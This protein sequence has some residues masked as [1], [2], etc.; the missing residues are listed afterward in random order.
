M[1]TVARIGG[2][3]LLAAEDRTFV[4]G[5]PKRPID[6]TSEGF[7]RPEHVDSPTTSD[8]IPWFEL[9]REP[10]SAVPRALQS[11][12]RLVFPLEGER[13]CEALHERLT[14][15]RNGSVSERLWDL[16][17][18]SSPDAGGALDAAWLAGVPLPVWEI[19]RDAVLTCV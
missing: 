16:V 2:A 7:E 10:G 8:R 11:E 6:W 5:E 15:R 17:V 12:P 1:S 3:L 4:V 13:A 9:S 14:I 18:E 19:V